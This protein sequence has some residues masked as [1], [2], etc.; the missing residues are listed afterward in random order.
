MLTVTDL[1]GNQVARDSSD[2]DGRY[3]LG[4]PTGGTYL[5]ICAEENHQ[6]V[7]SMITV[8]A[9]EVHRDIDL[10]GAGRIEGRVLRQDGNPVEAAAVTLTD[11][12]GDVVAAVVSKPSGEYVLADLYPGDYTLTAT[13]DGTRPAAH[14]I[15][16][17]GV[18][19]HKVDLVLL[20]HGTLAGIVRAASTGLAVRDASVTVVDGSGNVVATMVTGDD[21]RYE[22]N[23][24]LA[25]PY[26]LTASGYPPVASRVDLAGDRTD[27]DVMLGQVTGAASPLPAP[28]QRLGGR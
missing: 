23:D 24:L 7:A 27:R 10:I 11:A 19:A 2:G 18:G 4:L 21:G 13:A 16:V 20:S 12:R 8:A 22:F 14:S 5:L 15:T 28:A 17:E 3:R 26:T 9:G 6:P 25:A 1:Q